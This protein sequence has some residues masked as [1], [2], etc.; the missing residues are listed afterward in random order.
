MNSFGDFGR[1]E[2]WDSRY[3]DV[4]YTN[5]YIS[6]YRYVIVSDIFLHRMIDVLEVGRSKYITDSVTF[7]WALIESAISFKTIANNRLDGNQYETEENSLLILRTL[8][9]LYLRS[10]SL[11]FF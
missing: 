5:L 6:E 9:L 11:Y 2:A 8:H 7:A 1:H 4:D 3:I 10:S